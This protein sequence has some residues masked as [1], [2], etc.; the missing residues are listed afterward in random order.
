MN[1]KISFEAQIPVIQREIEKRRHKWTLAALSFEDASQIIMLRVFKKYHL[2]DP[3]KGEFSHWVNKV[4]SST[5]KNIM[6]DN[7]LKFSRPCIKGCAHNMGGD[8]CRKTPSGKQCD[9]CPL[10]KEWRMQK[11]QHFNIK[12]SLPLENHQQEVENHQC[13]FINIEE[14]KKVI[15][16]KMKLKLRPNEYKIYQLL[17]IE[18][19]SEEEVGT[20]MQYRK[21]SEKRSPGYQ[22]IAKAKAKIIEMARDIIKNED[23]TNG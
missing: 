16:E 19:L 3:Q 18:N 10:Y 15:D 12:Q 22:Q 1:K 11:E 20:K 17:Y 23:L 5:W 13:E 6:R 21:T 8:N 2:F 9:E 4:I 7:Y 14:K